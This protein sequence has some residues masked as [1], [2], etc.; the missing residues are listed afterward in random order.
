MQLPCVIIWD[1]IFLPGFLLNLVCL[2]LKLKALNPE[3]TE[4]FKGFNEKTQKTSK[5][6]NLRL[7]YEA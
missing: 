6:R 4:G 7:S 1:I 5:I 2:R 3:C